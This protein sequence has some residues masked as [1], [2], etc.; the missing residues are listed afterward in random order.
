MI[1]SFVFL[2]LCFGALSGT[3][4]GQSCQNSRNFFDGILESSVLEDTPTANVGGERIQYMLRCILD[5][6][7]FPLTDGVCGLSTTCCS[8][9]AI[10]QLKERSA[11]DLKTAL[12][13][14]RESATTSCPADKLKST[15]NHRTMVLCTSRCMKREMEATL[16]P[17]RDCEFGPC[18]RL[19]A[20]R[21]NGSTVRLG[22]VRDR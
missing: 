22:T 13:S 16:S 14:R 15:H 2:I 1:C 12:R 5:S 17:H 18:S 10:A 7:L 3:G 21:H 8:S 20:I 4:T 6:I 11:A 19:S 9:R